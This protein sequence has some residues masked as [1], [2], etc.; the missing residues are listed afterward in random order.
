MVIARLQL[1]KYGLTSVYQCSD[2]KIFCRNGRGLGQTF[3]G[4]GVDGDECCEAVTGDHFTICGYACSLSCV[5]A[6]ACITGWP[7]A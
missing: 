4:V 7:S 5:N 6:E 2:G 1:V 3:A